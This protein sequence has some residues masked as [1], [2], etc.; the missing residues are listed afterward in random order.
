M[1]KLKLYETSNDPKNPFAHLE[2]T[3]EFLIQNGNKS[4]TDPYF[5]LDQ[6]GWHCLLKNPIDFDFLEKRFE[7]P[8]SIS[9]SRENDSILDTRTWVEIKGG[10]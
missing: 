6:D 1:I 9:V 4:I 7:F 8:E 10:N 3:V 2:P 5:S